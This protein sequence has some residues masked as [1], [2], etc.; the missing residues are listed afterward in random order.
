MPP[1]PDLEDRLADLSALLAEP[2]SSLAR[3]QLAK[4]L[5]D[6][7]NHLV[8]KA[9]KIAGELG[10]DELTAELTAAFDRF[11]V[12]P[13]GTDKG[14]V[15]KSAILKTL[16]DLEAREEGRLPARCPSSADGALMG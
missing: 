1:R 8:G 11:M 16:V 2:D 9:A 12:D 7:S 15:A 13:A 10:F 4:A 5:G 3:R 6:R 14:C